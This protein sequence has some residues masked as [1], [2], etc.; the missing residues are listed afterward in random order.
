MD[1]R[2]NPVSGSGTASQE[3][4]G[5]PVAWAAIRSC[6]QRLAEPTYLSRG[7]EDKKPKTREDPVSL[8]NAAATQDKGPLPSEA[9]VNEHP[10]LE[11]TCPTAQDSSTQQL[12]D[13]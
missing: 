10:L 1:V 8:N 11:R 5:L 3:P 13:T 7:D 9:A 12:T 4:S 2:Q 6:W